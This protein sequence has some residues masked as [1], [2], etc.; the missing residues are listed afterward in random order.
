MEI[1][2]DVWLKQYSQVNS[3]SFSREKIWP[4]DFFRAVLLNLV[5]SL[6]RTEET[7]L[8]KTMLLRSLF[9]TYLKQLGL[10][11]STALATHQQRHCPGTYPLYVLQTRERYKKLA[12][13]AYQVDAYLALAHGQSPMLHRQEVDVEL[14]TTFGVWNAFGINV[15]SKRLSEEPVGRTASTIAEITKSPDSFTSSPLLIEDIHLGLCG[16]V[17]AVW[18]LTEPFPSKDNGYSNTAFQ[19]VLVRK[20]VV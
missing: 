10:F 7:I 5:F 1:A 8:S 12:A 6:Y 20:S 18:V 11:S 15:C 13:S 3:D 2:R 9:I 16:L 14:T 17:Q 19:K 4:I